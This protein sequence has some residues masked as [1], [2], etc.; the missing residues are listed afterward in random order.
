[1]SAIERLLERLETGWVPKRD[2]IDRD[3]KQVYLTRWVIID[4][5]QMKNHIVGFDEND[6]FDHGLVLHWGPNMDWV[7]TPDGFFWL[8][9]P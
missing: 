3:I 9:A 1:M 6:I 4:D 2:E 8:E 7:L 5:A